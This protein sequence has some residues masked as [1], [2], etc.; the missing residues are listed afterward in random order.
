MDQIGHSC[1]KQYAC[2]M[3][4]VLALLNYVE[5]VFCVSYCV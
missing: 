1:L 2:D 3:H 4:P 5:L